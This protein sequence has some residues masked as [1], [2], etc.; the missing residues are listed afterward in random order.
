MTK[1][2]R[3]PVIFLA[4]FMAF[5]FSGCG[6]T[7]NSSTPRS[8][9]LMEKPLGEMS[10]AEVGEA[11][12]FAACQLRQMSNEQVQTSFKTLDE[13]VAYETERTQAWTGY[14]TLLF[15]A[16]DVPK[17]LIP[18]SDEEQWECIG[19]TQA[20]GIPSADCW[21]VVLNGSRSS[22]Y[23]WIP[24][25]RAQQNNTDY[26]N[27]VRNGIQEYCGI[28]VDEVLNEMA[29]DPRVV[30]RSTREKE[31][32]EEEAALQE[33]QNQAEQNPDSFLEN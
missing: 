32:K 23:H 27:A 4:P 22:S 15:A 5:S 8:S 11:I 31:R 18:N 14:E 13:K 16:R 21:L 28:S 20:G 30:A 1:S 26:A 25:T 19:Q 24:W 17:N 33:R 3:L 12:A 2:F 9:S 10:I 6:D 7:N 29:S